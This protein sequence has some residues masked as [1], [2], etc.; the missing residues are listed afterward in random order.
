[1]SSL[2]DLANLAH[3]FA[4]DKTDMRQSFVAL[5]WKQSATDLEKLSIRFAEMKMLNLRDVCQLIASMKR[6]DAGLSSQ[7]HTKS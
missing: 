6:A 4:H 5:L 2:E 1:M 7:K 3:K